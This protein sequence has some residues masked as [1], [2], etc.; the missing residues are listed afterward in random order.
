MTT[1]NVQYLP[2]SRSLVTLT[3]SLAARKLVQDEVLRSKLTYTVIAVKAGL[4]NSTVSNIATGK[5]I[6]PRLETIVRVLAALGWVLMAQRR[7]G[8]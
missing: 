1:T 2:G 8:E 5:T 4:A 3:D 6:W 7:G